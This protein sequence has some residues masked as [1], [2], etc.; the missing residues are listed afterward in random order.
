MSR[1]SRFPS[2]RAGASRIFCAVR[3]LPAPWPAH[4]LGSE[5][6]HLSAAPLRSAASL[7]SDSA[8]HAGAAGRGRCATIGQL[9][10]GRRYRSC[11]MGP[12]TY[13]PLARTATTSSSGR[14]HDLR[15]YRSRS[16]QPGDPG[17]DRQRARGAIL[18]PRPAFED[19]SASTVTG[20]SCL[21][22]TLPASS[23]V[24]APLA[25]YTKGLD[26]YHRT[27]SSHAWTIRRPTL[28][29]SSAPT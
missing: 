5:Q 20:E 6:H 9:A 18:L 17:H 4:R 10:D 11:G 12:L 7:T 29:F 24:L 28:S 19:P 23:S 14:Q 27:S 8:H 13:S 21:P 3:P 26:A 1:L 15:L 25:R 16:G 2:A 22:R